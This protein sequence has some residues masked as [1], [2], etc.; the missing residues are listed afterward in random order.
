MEWCLP[1]G[2]RNMNHVGTLPHPACV[3]TSAGVAGVI[4]VDLTLKNLFFLV[5]PFF[6][7]PKII[8]R[9]DGITPAIP[10][11]NWC[12]YNPHSHKQVRLIFNDG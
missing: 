9:R 8:S 11:T 1:S 10:A 5:I 6:F 3:V 2:N 4:P 12:F 7:F